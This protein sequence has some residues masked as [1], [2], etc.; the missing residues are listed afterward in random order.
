MIQPAAALP[1]NALRAF[2]PFQTER[3][4]A[5]PR[6]AFERTNIA[7]SATR[8]SRDIRGLDTQNPRPVYRAKILLP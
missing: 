3:Q 7:E 8:T 6:A 1:E 4:K 5:A 2:S